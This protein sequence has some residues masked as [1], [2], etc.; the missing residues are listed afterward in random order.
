MSAGAGADTPIGTTKRPT[1]IRSWGGVAAFSLYDE[2]SSSVPPR[3]QPPGRAARDSRRRG[4]ADRL[5]P[6]RR[7]GRGGLA[8]DRVLTLCVD[9]PR[10]SRVR[11]LS[12]LAD[13]RRASPSS[14]AR[15]TRMR[16]RLPRP[17]GARASHGHGSPTVT[18]NP[19]ASHLHAQPERAAVAAF[20]T[21]AGHSVPP[22]RQGRLHR[23]R[24]RAPWAAAGHERR[25][26]GAGVQ[27]RADPAGLPGRTKH[28][29]RQHDLRPERTDNSSA[30]PS[31][32][33]TC[34]SRATAWPERCDFSSR[35]IPIFAQDRQVF[36]RPLRPA[37]D[38]L[39]VRLRRAGIRGPRARHC[40]RLLRQLD[41]RSTDTRG[42]ARLSDR[43]DGSAHLRSR[44]GATLS[45][46]GYRGRVGATMR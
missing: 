13:G 14:S 23:Q 20:A 2:A 11:P 43:P 6:R 36:P 16:R 33:A 5:R 32:R 39:L 8:R 40:Q 17:S 26:S 1:P 25:V 24:A 34:T 42:A 3:H 7:P 38:R 28:P 4:A 41:R 46:R 44:S 27:Q 18:R 10:P 30:S 45:S 22:L 9:S 21:A 37:P 19:Q 15:A 31:T 29:D 12:L 35:S